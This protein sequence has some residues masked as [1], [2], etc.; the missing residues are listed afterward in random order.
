MSEI[1]R[2]KKSKKRMPP[3]V[4]VTHSYFSAE[5]NPMP[6]KLKKAQE[7]LRKTRFPD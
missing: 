4:V 1:K 3:T 6:E 7:I 5:D 2:N